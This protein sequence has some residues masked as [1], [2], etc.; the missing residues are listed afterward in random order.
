M[1]V[2]TTLCDIQGAVLKP[3]EGFLRYR[4]E[5]SIEANGGFRPPHNGTTGFSKPEATG[6]LF[7]KSHSLCV[8]R[9]G[10]N[11]ALTLGL[12]AFGDGYG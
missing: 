11:R 4:V 3:T 10:L 12:D 1:P 5:A 9:E 6:V 7:G 2:H 8:I